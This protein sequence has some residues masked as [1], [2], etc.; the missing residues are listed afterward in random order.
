ML[1]DYCDIRIETFPPL[2]IFALF[3]FLSFLSLEDCSSSICPSFSG[4]SSV[5]STYSPRLI[6]WINLLGMGIALGPTVTV[7]FVFTPKPKVHVIGATVEGPA[8]PPAKGWVCVTA[9]G[10]SVCGAI[11]GMLASELGLGMRMVAE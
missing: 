11:K 2:D 8:G 6:F 3:H 1:V 9:S 10:D 7:W 5:I 4:K